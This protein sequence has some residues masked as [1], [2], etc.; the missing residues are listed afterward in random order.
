METV[1]LALIPWL[2]ASF[3]VTTGFVCLT[4]LCGVA[5]AGRED[6]PGVA[7]FRMVNAVVAAFVGLC[8][9]AGLGWL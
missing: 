3:V 1:G 9:A 6:K 4:S 5:L 7:I 2:P 8:V